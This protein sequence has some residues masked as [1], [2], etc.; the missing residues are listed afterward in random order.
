MDFN[1]DSDLDPSLPDGLLCCTKSKL[2]M[3]SHSWSAMVSIIDTCYV[4]TSY[5][6]DCMTVIDWE[7]P[8][9]PFFLEVFG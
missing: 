4:E 9:S 7:A 5:E 8:R 2:R 3:D 1:D 6:L